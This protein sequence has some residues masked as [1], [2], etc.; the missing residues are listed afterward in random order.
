MT[1]FRFLARSLTWL[2]SFLNHVDY[3]LAADLRTC[4]NQLLYCP[5]CWGNINSIQMKY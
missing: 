2:D 3:C 4:S 5:K 1:K